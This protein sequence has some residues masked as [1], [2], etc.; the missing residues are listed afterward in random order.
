MKDIVEIHFWQLAAAYL[1]ILIPLFIVKIIGINREQ[2]IL[3]SALRMTL[4]LFLMGYVLTYILR[5]DNIF[6]ILLIIVTMEIF[7]IINIYQRTK[8]TISKKLKGIVALAMISGTF[9]CIL[10]FT[11]VVVPTSP[12]YD[13]RYIIPLSGMLIGN[14]MTGIALGANRLVNDMVIQKDLI[15]AALMLGATPKDAVREIVKNAF[16]S[17]FLPTL[18][19]MVGM[20]IVFLPGMMTGQI[21]AGI[22]PVSAIKYQMAITLGIVGSVSLSVIIFVQLGYKTFFNKENQF[23]I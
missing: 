19:S 10:Y 11:L 13:P 8:K 3:F 12:W 23:T 14:T 1:F 17:A 20:G 18:N 5:S 4:Q 6:I 9:A 16:D 21:I 22:A 7:A 15:E 2:E